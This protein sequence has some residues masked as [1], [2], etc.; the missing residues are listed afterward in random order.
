MIT[1]TA[2]PCNFGSS[3][4]NGAAKMAIQ[5]TV[6]DGVPITVIPAPVLSQSDGE[7]CGAVPPAAGIGRMICLLF[8]SP[9]T[10]CIV[11]GLPGVTTVTLF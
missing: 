6:L 8:G 7:N 3:L 9:A 5:P 11:R 2:F 1:I 10:E 4:F